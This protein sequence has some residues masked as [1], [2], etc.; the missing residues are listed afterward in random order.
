MKIDIS[1][2]GSL[3]I[4]TYLGL[5]VVIFLLFLSYYNSNILFN[6]IGSSDPFWYVG[7][8]LFYHIS[9]Y[10]NDYYKISRLPW[11]ILEFLARQILQPAS[12]TFVLQAFC[13]STGSIALFFLFREIVGKSKSF[14]IAALYIFV[15]L[16]QASSAGA[17]YH[18]TFSGAMFFLTFALLVRAI[19]QMS[20]PS[21]F[22][23]GAIGAAMLHTNLLFLFVSPMIALYIFGLLVERRRTAR[24]IFQAAG[25]VLAGFI[26]A[27]I[28]FSL[29]HASFGRG[30]L[31][32]V[33]Q[34]EVMFWFQ[35]HTYH[36]WWVPLSWE[37]LRNDTEN[38]WLFSIFII[39]CIELI[40]TMTRQRMR[41][42]MH[43]SAANLGFILSYVGAV[44][45]QLAGQTTLMPNYFS[46]PFLAATMIPLGYLVDKYVCTE[47][48]SVTVYLA[49]PLLC[50]S[51]LLLSPE[52]DMILSL[53]PWSRFF[54]VFYVSATVYLLMVLLNSTPLR[55]GLVLLALLNSVLGSRAAS[56]Y[57]YDPCHPRRHFNVLLA[58]MSQMATDLARKPQNVFVWYDLEDHVHASP[59]FDGLWMAYLGGSF[60]AIAH[61]YFGEPATPMNQFTYELFAQVKATEGVIALV[62]TRDTT[63]DQFIATAVSLGVDLRLA[64]LYQDRASGVKFYFFK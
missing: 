24:F 38:A 17:D 13:Y 54:Q 31:F 36:F 41:E 43:A 57:S 52:V 58:L 7:I 15:P 2:Y 4:S 40:I 19:S 33:P 16:L 9:D 6:H 44:G 56:N 12:A 42:D 37:N 29:A 50:A 21:S 47:P 23:A 48:N 55:I 63:K 34:I 10:S 62:A 32:F 25:L 28:L 26:S 49:F 39:C 14:I 51:L 8:G 46:Y 18:N 35:Q 3:T 61:K 59:C 1:R 60:T 22:A 45:Y 20:K 64:G 53:S 11:N 30:F 5:L 27:T